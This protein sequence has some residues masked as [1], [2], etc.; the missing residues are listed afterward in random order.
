MTEPPA[1]PLPAQTCLPIN[2]CNLPCHA[3]AGLAYQRHPAAITIDGVQALHHQLFE[4]LD[5]ERDAHH[6]AGHFSNH[7]RA[8]FQLADPDAL[9][10]DEHSR[11]PGRIHADYRQLL[12]G[13]LFNA[14]GRE[15]AVIKGW[16]ESRFGLQTRN[17]REALPDRDGAAY[18]AYQAELA[19]ALYNTSALFDQ[20]DL[21]YSYC[22]Y[23]LGRRYPDRLQIPHYR[24]LNRLGDMDVV[25]TPDARHTVLLLNN[26]N[27]FS[28]S[29]ERA[30][31]F[32]DC[33]IRALVPL[34]KL[35]YVPELIP[36]VLQGEDEHLVIGGLYEVE[37]LTS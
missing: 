8:C 26:I 16:V 7:M 15:A 10:Y 28:G 36:G 2:R 22:Q 31:E 5:G 4:V 12:R 14:D 1:V 30:D 25:A 37:R 6:R 21:L 18:Q 29:Q 33:V 24:G 35:L 20:L 13:W 23:E 9:G 11:R 34:S 27:S 3:L 17:H 32:G 19:E